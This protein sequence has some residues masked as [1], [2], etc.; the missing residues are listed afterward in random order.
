MMMQGPVRRRYRA[1]VPAI[2]VVLGIIGAWFAGKALAFL[3]YGVAPRDPVT[4]IA[5]ALILGT[6]AL[7]ASYFPARRAGRVEP[8][9]ALRYE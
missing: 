8:V 6:V 5:V 2:G 7:A 1:R 9:I 4:L 3:L